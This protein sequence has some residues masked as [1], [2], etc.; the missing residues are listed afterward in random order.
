M[1]VPASIEQIKVIAKR[2]RKEV[3]EATLSDFSLSDALEL[4]SFIF[5]FD[6]GYKEMRKRIRGLPHSKWDCDCDPAEVDNR[7]S[8]Q[9]NIILALGIDRDIAALIIDTVRPTEKPGLKEAE[10]VPACAALP[11]DMFLVEARRLLDLSQ[12]EPAARCAGSGAL[13]ASSNG[14]EPYLEVI[15]TCAEHSDAV[16][17]DIAHD[18]LN[19]WLFPVDRVR[20]ASELEALHD[21]QL[22]DDVR[23]KVVSILGEIATGHYGG[24]PHLEKAAR[25]FGEAGDLGSDVGD[26]NAGLIY[27]KDLK[28]YAKAA[29]YLSRAAGSGNVKA[30]SLYGSL[31][32]AGRVPGSVET[33]AGLI[34]RAAEEGDREAIILRPHL[35]ASLRA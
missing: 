24:V 30:M 28:D 3:M 27:S 6:C 19:G 26:L 7:R 18:M 35:L 16:R 20:A 2:L 4:T 15:V 33:A 21:K 17:A 34:I 1:F 5:G 22:R 10:F 14:R 25:L 31:M 13:R 23:L 12:W 8:F 9:I 11:A 32:W 29:R